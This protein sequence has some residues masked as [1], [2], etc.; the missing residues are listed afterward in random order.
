MGY[1]RHFKKM[2]V[3]FQKTS[4]V[5]VMFLFVDW[6]VCYQMLVGLVDLNQFPEITFL[7]LWIIIVLLFIWFNWNGC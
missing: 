4:R 1:W 3:E 6:V 5:S 2:D 7:S